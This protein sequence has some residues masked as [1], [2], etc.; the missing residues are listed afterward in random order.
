MTAEI[1]FL[2]VE[3]FCKIYLH[4]C[5]YICIYMHISAYMQVQEFNNIDITNTYMGMGMLHLN[6]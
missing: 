6:W 2:D 5:I 4:I 3:D 1:L